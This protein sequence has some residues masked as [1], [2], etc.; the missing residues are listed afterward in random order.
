MAK[1]TRS[2]S[3]RAF[4]RIKRETGTFAANDA[5]RLQRLSAK[6]KH[7]A[8]ADKDGDVAIDDGEEDDTGLLCSSFFEDH[9]RRPSE[10]TWFAFAMF[11][12]MDP[13]DINVV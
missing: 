6:L 3:K 9:R 1:S 5:A 12:L 4:R 11:G 7:V 8:D 13:D 2:K 10:A